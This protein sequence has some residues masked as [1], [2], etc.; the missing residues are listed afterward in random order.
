MPGLMPFLKGTFLPSILV[1][2]LQPVQVSIYVH[3]LYISLGL[4]HQIIHRSETGTF[5]L[6]FQHLMLLLDMRKNRA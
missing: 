2:K 5:I 6:F 3:A 4:Q 1:L